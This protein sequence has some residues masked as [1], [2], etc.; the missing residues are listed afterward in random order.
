MGGRGPRPPPAVP[1]TAQQYG[2][3]GRAARGLGRLV[4]RY[5][6]ARPVR[7][8]RRPYGDYYGGQGGYLPP[9]QQPY[10]PGGHPQQPHQPQQHFAQGQGPDRNPGTARARGGAAEP[11]GPEQPRHGG[12][13]Q[14]PEAV[15][16]DPEPDEPGGGFFRD[17]DPEDPYDDERLSGRERRGKQPKRRS[18]VACLVV[19]VVLAGVIGGGGYYGYQFWQSHFGA[20]RTTRAR[21]PDRSTSRCPTARAAP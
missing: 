21:A 9:E 8:A 20:R 2:G 4:R 16:P 18:G 12:P 17:D 5:G 1:R 11:V 14:A 15:L 10:G 6:P 3:D 13:A 19:T 7:P